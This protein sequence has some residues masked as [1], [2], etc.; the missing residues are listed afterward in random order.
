[1]RIY[2]LVIVSIVFAW[3][4][5]QNNISP[6]SEAEKYKVEIKRFEKD[7]F[8]ISLDRMDSSFVDLRNNYPAFFELFNNRIINIGSSGTPGYNERLL[9]FITNYDVN[10]GYNKVQEVFSDLSFLENQL[11]SAFSY[12]KYYFKEKKIPE[13]LTFISGYNESIVISDSLLAIG[14]DKYLGSDCDMYYK[15]GFPGYLRFK[16]NKDEIAADCINSWL[17]T[18]YVYNDSVDNLLSQMVYNGKILY[19]TKKLMPNMADT[20]I[21]GYS[22][23]Q[24]EFC[25]KNEK[26]MWTYLAEQQLLFNSDRLTISKFIND[27]PFTRDFSNRSP[28]RAVTW[29]GWKITESYMRKNKASVS[30]LMNNNNYM[31][32]YNKSRYVP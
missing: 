5:K 11:S 32:I 17:R 19:V 30:Q 3:G 31:D 4:C 28:A 2:C 13:V 25:I 16:M 8:A 26:K 12:Y 21:I 15:I 29:I 10:M 14:L 18:E 6:D 20:L 7:L 22:G 9:E 27:G 23:E 24:L 1:M